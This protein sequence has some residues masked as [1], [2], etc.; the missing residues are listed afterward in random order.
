[1]V[2]CIAAGAHLRAK[3]AGIAF[4]SNAAYKSLGEVDLILGGPRRPVL[5]VQTSR[6]PQE[7]KTS[8]MSARV[9]SSDVILYG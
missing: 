9:S 3:K 4:V 2:F 6:R 7:F 5:D 1:M 8:S